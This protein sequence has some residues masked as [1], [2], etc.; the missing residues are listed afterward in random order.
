MN[1]TPYLRH[2]PPCNLAFRESAPAP[3]ERPGAAD[4]LGVDDG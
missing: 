1:L 4:W 2:R 3:R